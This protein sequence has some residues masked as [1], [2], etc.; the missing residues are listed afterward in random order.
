MGPGQGSRD[1]IL[2][3]A[4]LQKKRSLQWHLSARRLAGYSWVVFVDRAE[5]PNSS[6]F[7]GCAQSEA[8]QSN[9]IFLEASQLVQRLDAYRYA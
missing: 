9:R 7:S 3:R 6:K 5:M 4:S 8:C 1:D 2:G